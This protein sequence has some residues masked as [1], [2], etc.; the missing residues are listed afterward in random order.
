MKK[1]SQYFI[2]NLIL[3]SVLCL[4]AIQNPV[5]AQDKTAKIDKFVH[6]YAAS[7]CLNGTVLVAEKGSVIYKKAFGMANF[8]WGIPN[9]VDTKFRIYSMSKPFTAL[10]VMQLV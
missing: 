7:G 3:A 6:Q 4:S 2:N 8:E 5:I 1:A 10:L 9:T